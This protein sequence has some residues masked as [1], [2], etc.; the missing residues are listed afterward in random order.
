[1]RINT[2]TLKTLDK[3]TLFEYQKLFPL[4][5]KEKTKQYGIIAL[6]FFT[7]TVFGIF[8]V[9]PT[10]TT[11]VELHKTL[12]DARFVDQRLTQKI[13]NL[14]SLNQ[15]YITLEKD[16]ILVERAIPLHP[17]PILL[18]GQ[19]QTIAQNSDVLI[20]AINVQEI[21]ISGDPIKQSNREPSA[22]E[23]SAQNT[24]T[25]MYVFDLTINGTYP[26]IR[27]FATTLTNFD[28]LVTV[29]ELNI[30]RESTETQSV[31]MSIKG[32]AYFKTK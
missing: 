6:T 1:M 28:R 32:T 29:N 12:D 17:E 10:L 24:N 30:S 9:N 21:T 31:K 13:T 5:K 26:Q 14:Q 16:I 18:I 11:I 25:D 27:S 22:T 20:S 3:K 23:T 15:K 19:F 4:L 7:M 8:A 2:Q